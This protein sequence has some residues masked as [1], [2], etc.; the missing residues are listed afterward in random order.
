MLETRKKII[1]TKIPSRATYF[2]KKGAKRTG[3]GTDSGSRGYK[4]TWTS[5]RSPNDVPR[6]TTC[7][8]P[9]ISTRSDGTLGKT[10]KRAFLITDYPVSIP[11][12]LPWGIIPS[13]SEAPKRKGAETVPRLAL[14]ARGTVLVKCGARGW[15]MYNM[16]A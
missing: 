1:A 14:A 8:L 13:W 11:V 9:Q 2:R 15:Q 3:S 10:A 4:P 6:R 5:S 12:C 16:L 7:L